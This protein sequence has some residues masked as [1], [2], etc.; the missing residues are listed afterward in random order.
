MRVLVITSEPI[1]ARQL[2][3]GLGQDTALDDVEVMVVAPAVQENPI[4]FWMSDADERDRQS[5]G[6]TNR[7]GRAARSGGNPGG[8]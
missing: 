5:Q 6:G 7:D 3:D 1:S 8:R 4:K 2:R